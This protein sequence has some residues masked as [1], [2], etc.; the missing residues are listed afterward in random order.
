VSGCG[1]DQAGLRESRTG[2]MWRIRAGSGTSCEKDT[3]QRLQAGPGKGK[4]NRG[5]VLQRN[6]QTRF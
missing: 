3:A 1:W 4:P 5:L 2:P 6:M